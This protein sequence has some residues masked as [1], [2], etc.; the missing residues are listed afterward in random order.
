MLVVAH[1]GMGPRDVPTREPHSAATSSWVDFGVST[2]QTTCLRNPSLDRIVV[3]P[4]FESHM[5]RCC[6]SCPQALN[7]PTAYAHGTRTLSDTHPRMTPNA[8]PRLATHATDLLAPAPPATVPHFVA[9]HDD[10]KRGARKSKRAGRDRTPPALRIAFRARG[11][12]RRSVT[13]L[14]VPA[15]PAAPPG[16]TFPATPITPTQ[17]ES[18]SSNA[19]TMSRHHPFLGFR[20]TTAGALPA[21]PTHWARSWGGVGGGEG[22][23]LGARG[24]AEG[25]RVGILP[26]R[27]S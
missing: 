17:L 12:V 20:K 13:T 6:S 25:R 22:P 2:D 9:G 18:T 11:R 15:I 24:I 4:S 8:P 19:P 3:P 14:V 23:P 21:A 27:A 7:D 5:G 1:A 10:S 26:G 16:A